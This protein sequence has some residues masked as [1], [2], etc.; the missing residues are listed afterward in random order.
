MRPR[1]SGQRGPHRQGAGAP[2]RAP[3]GSSLAQSLLAP[4]APPNLPTSGAWG[5][6]EWGWW[7]QS[8]VC[9]PLPS[10][11]CPG[12]RGDRRGRAQLAPPLAEE[13]EPERE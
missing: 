5:D 8:P 2:N 4:P 13:Q 12:R 6:L 9:P 7:P 11:T 3:T 1:A 10:L